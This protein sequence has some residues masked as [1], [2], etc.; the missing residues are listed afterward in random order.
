M[1]YYEKLLTLG[2]VTRSQLEQ[3]TGSP[4]A[5]DWLCREYQRK[6]YLERIKRN[7]YA[8]I[9]LETGQSVANRY[10][11]ASHICDDAVVSYHSAFEYYGYANQVFYEVQVTSMSRFR[12]F[13][14]DGITYRHIGQ[15]IES[16]VSELP[17]GIRVTTLERTVIDSINLFEKTGGLEELLRCLALIPSLDESKLTA[18]LS[19]YGSG[20]LYQKAGYI[21]SHFAETLGLSDA[22]FEN[23][24]AHIPKGKNYL[25]E[26]GQDFV[27]HEKWKLYA[28]AD[29]M[30][31]TNKG[32]TGYDAI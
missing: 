13:S 2:C 4:S 6:G 1:K 25:Y 18:C 14:Y 19:E 32:V 29:L 9:S 21:L 11:I 20:I 30:Q 12:T 22:F 31:L 23:C 28:P 26:N 15:R 7:L 24:A 10:K 16:G 5:A 17:N 27:W 3:V 8:V